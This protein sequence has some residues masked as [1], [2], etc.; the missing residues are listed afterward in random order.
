MAKTLKDGETYTDNN[1]DVWGDAVLHVDNTR[2]NWLTQV[3]TMSVCIYKDTAARTAGYDPIKQ[4]ISITKA[5]FLANF[6]LT[7]AITT[8]KTQCETYALTQ[9]DLITGNLY[10]DLFE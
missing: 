3:L 9:I 4:N 1:G 6:T 10:S 2:E 7:D 8:L 5:E